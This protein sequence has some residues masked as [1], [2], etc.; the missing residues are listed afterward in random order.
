M[1]G[2]VATLPF[3]VG[4]P[5]TPSQAVVVSAPG[6]VLVTLTVPTAS[7]PF[8]A[9]H[10]RATLRGSGGARA[11]ATVSS[12]ELVPQPTGGYVV[13]LLSSTA[14]SDAFPAGTS[15]SI[16]IEVGA[17]GDAVVVPLTAI[18]RSG[19]LAT[20]RLLTGTEVTEV[21]VTLG[22]IGDTRAEVVEGV[23]PGDRLVVADATKPIPG[24][25]LGG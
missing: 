25:G 2:V 13:T 9:T 6:A 24:F 15:V 11:D 7:Y 16:E 3:T 22:R 18:T 23:H 5:A 12:K 10:Q 21:P 14:R 17:V 1:A 4:S 8:V 20:V 19:D